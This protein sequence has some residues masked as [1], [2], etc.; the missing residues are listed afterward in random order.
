M[1][2]TTSNSFRKEMSRLQAFSALLNASPLDCSD[3]MDAPTQRGQF[4]T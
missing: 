4:H 1:T 2:K 3:V